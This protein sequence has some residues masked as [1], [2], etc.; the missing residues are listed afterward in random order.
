ML[1]KLIIILVLNLFSA[2]IRYDSIHSLN[3]TH[4]RD[5]T[6]GKAQSSDYLGPTKQVIC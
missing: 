1:V 6:I 2:G 4:P 5:M 3:R